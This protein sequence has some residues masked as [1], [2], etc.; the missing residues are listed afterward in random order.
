LPPPGWR[1]PHQV[2]IFFLLESPVH[3]DL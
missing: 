2:F 1:R 3:T